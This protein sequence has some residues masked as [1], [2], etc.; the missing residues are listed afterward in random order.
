ME[1]NA[2][3]GTRRYVV[4]T[5]KDIVG[6]KLILRPRTLRAA[7]LAKCRLGGHIT[8]P[9]RF[10]SWCHSRHRLTPAR[11]SAGGGT[12]SRGA[13]QQELEASEVLDHKTNKM[14]DAPDCSPDGPVNLADDEQQPTE[15][16]GVVGGESPCV[17]RACRIE[18]GSHRA[19]PHRR[20]EP[21][22]RDVG[23]AGHGPHQ[24]LDA[25]PVHVLVVR[26]SFP[27]LAQTSSRV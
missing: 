2:A 16:V 23:A 20:H 4:A 27:L 9:L 5:S 25:R 11:S 13:A 3:W 19:P 14:A 10:Q 22:R 1:P 17:P 6:L 24:L 8:R 18:A 15:E 12:T 21:R 7:E 26:P